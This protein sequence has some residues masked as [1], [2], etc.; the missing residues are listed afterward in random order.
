MKRT[1]FNAIKPNFN[2]IKIERNMN[3]NAE[4][5]LEICQLTQPKIKIE[6]N[7]H[8]ANWPNKIFNFLKSRIQLEKMY[9]MMGGSNLP[10][11]AQNILN[12][13][14]NKLIV[15]L[16]L[17]ATQFGESFLPRIADGELIII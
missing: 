9:E 5:R 7:Q 13:L 10:N 16:D 11:D 3:Y 1:L 14:Q 8:I 4:N 12:E 17:L 6:T 15:R 2:C